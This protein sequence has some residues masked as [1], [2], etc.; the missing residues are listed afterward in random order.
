MSDKPIPPSVAQHALQ[1][2][3]S[4]NGE[5]I[6]MAAAIAQQ[7]ELIRLQAAEIAAL[8]QAGVGVDERSAFEA[9]R[10][11]TFCGG[12]ER[13]KKCSNAPDVYYYTAE[14]EA[15]K[16]WQARARLNASR[17][18]AQPELAVWCGAM[19]ESNGKSN[20]T[21]RLHRKGE[22]LLSG[23]TITLDRSEYPDRVRYEA[24]RVRYLIG[25][26]PT[27][28][29]ILAYDPDKHSGYAAPTPAPD[30]SAD[31][32]KMIRVPREL[33]ERLTHKESGLPYWDALNEDRLAAIVEL[34][35]LLAGGAQ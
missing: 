2:C 28:P 13:L 15:W 26:L 3:L 31:D 20:Y 6:G 17:D 19:P 32:I 14:Q 22:S 24:D 7:A 25:E 29:D 1:S 11:A 9:W 10:L 5:Q 33:L 8:K 34:R 18:V 16:V 23:V 21:A 35:A 27:E 12:D 30:H 4:E